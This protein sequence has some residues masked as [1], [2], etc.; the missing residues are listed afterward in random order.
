MNG[1]GRV[2]VVDDEPSVCALIRDGLAPYGFR[3]TTVSE[4]RKAKHL[5]DHQGFSVMVTDVA[6]EGLGGLDLLAHA[7]Q[8]TPDCKVILITGKPS[9]EVLAEALSLGAY[10]YFPKPFDIRRLVDT[11]KGAMVD[12]S[13]SQHLPMRAAKAMEM[14]SRLRETSLETIRALAHAVEAKDPYT[15]RHSEQVTHYALNIA[16]YLERPAKEIE[17]IRIAAL[18]HDIGKIGIPDNILTKPGAL[19]QAELA[20]VRKHPILGSEILSNITIFEQE[21]RL[22]RYHHENWDGSGYPD[23]LAAEEIPLGA[24][25]INVADSM[26]AMLMKRTYKR[27]YSSRKMLRELARCAGRQFD[28]QIAAAAIEWCNRHPKKLILAR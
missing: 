1:P 12:E 10:D 14:E 17:S 11:I 15:R 6:M 8:S 20:M 19:E 22:V 2:L 9:A 4:P 13:G 28:P 21:A 24:R 3:C 5:L 23:G 27:A 26:D 7:R 16:E 25:I 18:L